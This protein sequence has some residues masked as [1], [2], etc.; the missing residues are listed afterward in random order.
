MERNPAGKCNYRLFSLAFSARDE[1]ATAMPFKRNVCPP[2][3][4]RTGCPLSSFDI[5]Y[6]R[7]GPKRPE[8]FRKR[9][10]FGLNVPK[11]KKRIGNVSVCLRFSPL[12]RNDGNVLE[13]YRNRIGNEFPENV[14]KKAGTTETYWKRKSKRR[15]NESET[16]ALTNWRNFGKTF[17]E[18][19]WAF[20]R[21]SK[22]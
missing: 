16:F 1:P 3:C 19:L 17:P 10:G 7:K 4:V 12:G 18:T 13:T 5:T 6:D 20:W 9:F 11:T 14:E 15:K 2:R 22:G 8:R 21:F